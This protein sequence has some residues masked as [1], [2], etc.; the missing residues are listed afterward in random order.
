MTYIPVENFDNET[1]AWA[2]E[3]AIADFGA[4]QAAKFLGKT[5]DAAFF[6]KRYKLYE[7]YF[8]KE[9]GHFVG[10]HENGKFRRPFDP[11]MAKHRGNDY[12]E[13]N[14]WQYTWLVPQD[15]HGLI[16]LFGGDKGFINK[17]DEFVN[18]P[19]HLEDASPDIS[20]MI[21]QYAQGNEPNHHVPYLYNYAGEPWKGAKLVHQAMTEYYTNS[22]DG[23]CG[24]DDVGQMSA[25]YVFSSMG[26]YPAN[27]MDGKYVFGSPLMESAKINLPNGKN[28]EI[29]VKNY[30]K[31]NIYINKVTLN[32]KPHL[33]SFITHEDIKAGGKLVFEMSAK[34]NKKFGAN[35]TYRP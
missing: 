7:L 19:E 35:K 20:G 29:E 18:L 27:P 8:D 2:L 33:H 28:F 23:L 12:C 1:V 4:Y 10:L 5:E 30:G 24:N 13:G 32:G 16:N 22:P 15:V 17:L 31:N 26:F 11:F 14:A 25:W 6:E 9:V 21:G 34:P 3:Y